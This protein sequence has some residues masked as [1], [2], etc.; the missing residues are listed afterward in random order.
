MSNFQNLKKLFKK[1]NLNYPK[2]YE[3]FDKSLEIFF[4]RIRF[5]FGVVI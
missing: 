2:N 3:K 5:E 1:S 4:I